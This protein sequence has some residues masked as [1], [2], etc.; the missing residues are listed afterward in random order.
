M[1]PPFNHHGY[2][3]PGIHRAA[4]D[5]IETCFG[6]SNPER[7]EL[8]QSLRWLV[9]MCHQDDVLRLIVNGSFVTAKSDPEDVDCVLLGGPH[10]PS[11]L[12][13]STNGEVHCLLSI[14]KLP[15]L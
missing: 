14:L 13:K 1:I 9:D 8:M 2:L 6:T 5:E 11:T 4:L 10:S 12:S 7:R 15:M 3:P